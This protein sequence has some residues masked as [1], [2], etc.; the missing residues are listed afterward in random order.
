MQHSTHYSN[1]TALSRPHF[2]CDISRHSITMGIPA[3]TTISKVNFVH[4]YFYFTII[5]PPLFFCLWQTQLKLNQFTVNTW[6]R[7]NKLSRRS[8]LKVCQHPPRTDADLAAYQADHV[9]LQHFRRGFSG[10][11]APARVRVTS[12]RLDFVYS[13]HHFDAMKITIKLTFSC[14]FEHCFLIFWLWPS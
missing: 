13:P 11:P 9:A 14:S 6:T 3:P 12:P 4:N 5:F 7:V 10:T 2:L 8:I 1:N